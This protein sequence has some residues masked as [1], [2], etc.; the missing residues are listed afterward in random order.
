M[1]FDMDD[2]WNSIREEYNL[3][4]EKLFKYFNRT[5]INDAISNGKAFIF[6]HNPRSSKSGSLVEEWKHIKLRLK[7]NDNN[8]VRIGE[9]WYVRK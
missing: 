9:F 7:L 5:A 6:T 1:Y 2:E 3:T 8:L 4:Y